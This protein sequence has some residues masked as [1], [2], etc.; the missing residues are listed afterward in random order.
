MYSISSVLLIPPPPLWQHWQPPGKQ[1]CAFHRCRAQSHI[2]ANEECYAIGA[3][4][5]SPSNRAT[6]VA[7]SVVTELDHLG[8]LGNGGGSGDGGALFP[9]PIPSDL[10]AVR[11]RKRKESQ[12]CVHAKVDQKAQALRILI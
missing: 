4:T 12:A 2:D 8:C 6:T 9:R 5:L 1:S 10:S 7:A 3:G 11:G